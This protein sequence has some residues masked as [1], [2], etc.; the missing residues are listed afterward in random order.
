MS[1]FKDYKAIIHL[2]AD[3]LFAHVSLKSFNP[4]CAALRAII[5][6]DKE[7]MFDV[8]KEIFVTI[9]DMDGK[10]YKFGVKKVLKPEYHVRDL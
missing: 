10:H 3:M 8:G 4:E 1:K 6:V 9:R 2:G 5:Q 7:K